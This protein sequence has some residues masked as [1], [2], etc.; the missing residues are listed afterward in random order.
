MENK[1]IYVRVDSTQTHVPNSYTEGLW[2]RICNFFKGRINSICSHYVVS[3][4]TFGDK[5]TTWKKYTCKEFP[6]AIFRCEKVTE[7]ARIGRPSDYSARFVV[8]DENTMSG[9]F[10][11][12]SEL[13]SFGK[14]IEL[15]E[16][17]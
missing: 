3:G 8:I 4:F 12:Y 1:K 14:I 15:I 6:N 5:L 7:V 17:E 11:T 10:V 16:V 9:T 2:K 13:N